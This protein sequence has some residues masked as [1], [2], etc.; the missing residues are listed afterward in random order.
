MD[1]VTATLFVGLLSPDGGF[2]LKEELLLPSHP[3]C[4]EYMQR[5]YPGP[6]TKIPPGHRLVLYCRP[7]RDI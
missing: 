1:A 5:H 4:M 3:E 7:Q 6:D 2:A